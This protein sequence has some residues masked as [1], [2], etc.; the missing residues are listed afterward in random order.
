M[1]ILAGKRIL[2]T[3]ALAQNAELVQKLE[4]RGAIALIYPCLEIVFLPFELPNIQFDWVVYTSKNAMQALS[5]CE[6]GNIQIARLTH[7][8]KTLAKLFENEPPQKILLPQGDLADNSLQEALEKS[9]H[10]VTRLITY[11][12]RKPIKPAEFNFGH[13]D[14]ITFTSP[15]AAKNFDGERE[16]VTAACIGTTTYQAA[17]NLGFEKLICAKEHSIDG[18]VQILE[19]YFTWNS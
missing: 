19:E 16:G 18:L 9:G 6:L 17:Q 2:V 12:T 10:Q 15:S 4:S 13:L 3:R 1:S 11:S 5:G 8:S 7:N 14:A